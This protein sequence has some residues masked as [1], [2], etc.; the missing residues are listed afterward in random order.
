MPLASAGL[1]PFPPMR[2]EAA[3]TS[4]GGLGK[5]PWLAAPEAPAPLPQRSLLW[6][7]G[8]CALVSLVLWVKQEMVQEVVKKKNKCKN[9]FVLIKKNAAA[10]S[11]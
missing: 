3:A 4:P 9:L 11:V 10:T 2:A 8:E 1:L 7:V 6:V 5:P